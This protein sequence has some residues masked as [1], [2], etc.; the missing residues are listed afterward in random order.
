MR[1]DHASRSSV[2][3]EAARSVPDGMLNLCGMVSADPFTVGSR[4]Y[5][6]LLQSGEA[7]HGEPLH[8]RQH[9]HDLFMEIV[10]IYDHPV[11]NDLAV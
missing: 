7:Y 8:D 6:L 3:I 11:G 2:P 5:P 1:R 4:G 10:R 9:P